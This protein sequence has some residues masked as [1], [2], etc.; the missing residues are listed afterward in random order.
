ML[1]AVQ[2][3]DSELGHGIKAAGPQLSLV[4]WVSFIYFF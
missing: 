1:E 2:S 3:A 4:V